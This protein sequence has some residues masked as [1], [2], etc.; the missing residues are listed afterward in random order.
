MSGMYCQHSGK[1]R[2]PTPA[3][4]RKALDAIIRRKNGKARHYQCEV[5]KDWHIANATNLVNER[6]KPLVRS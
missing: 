6:R 4:A 2:Y 5:C 1:L 3:K